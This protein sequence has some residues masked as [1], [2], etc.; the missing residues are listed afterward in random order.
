MCYALLGNVGTSQTNKQ[1][2]TLKVLLLKH[3]SKDDKNHIVFHE[4]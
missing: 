4:K 2:K 3:Q 1:K